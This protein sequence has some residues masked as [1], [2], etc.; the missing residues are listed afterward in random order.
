MPDE[1]STM[2]KALIT[3]GGGIAGVWLRLPEAMH[4][5]FYVMAA[6]VLTGLCRAGMAGEINSSCSFRGMMKKAAMVV[7]AGLGVVL[8]QEM[9]PNLH[10]G[11]I[12]A[13]AFTAVEGFSIIENAEAMGLPL[14]RVLRDVF[15]NMRKNAYRQNRRKWQ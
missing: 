13:M 3:L 15:S 2:F 5:M 12:L 9:R 11:S 14:P 7:I 4:I 1:R 6:D 10:L 8:D